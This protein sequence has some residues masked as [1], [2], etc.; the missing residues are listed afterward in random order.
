MPCV[1]ERRDSASRTLA[2]TELS[3]ASCAKVETLPVEMAPEENPFMA[4]SKFPVETCFYL[5]HDT[6]TPYG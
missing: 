6:P 4:R 5:T 1:L 2:S 3:P